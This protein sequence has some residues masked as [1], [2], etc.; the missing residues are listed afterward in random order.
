MLRNGDKVTRWA[1]VLSRLFFLKSFC[2]E[3][4][5]VRLCWFF[6]LQP[7]IISYMDKK[8]KK[9][10]RG[11]E[12]KLDAILRELRLFGFRPGSRWLDSVR[13]SARKLREM[14]R[15]ERER[16]ERERRRGLRQ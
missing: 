15:E 2:S 16:M 1:R 3:R 7:T 5:F 14:S 4:T 8:L 12:M 10:L 6:L 11:I 13:S 9:R